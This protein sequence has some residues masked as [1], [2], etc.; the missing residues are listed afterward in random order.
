M[1]FAVK[2]VGKD[3]AYQWYF[4]R[5]EGS[6]K[7]VAAASYNTAALV[8]TANTKNDGTKFR[9]RIT[10]GLGNILVSSAATLTQ[11]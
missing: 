10:D 3:L 2:A 5:P 6:W 11:S 8:I 9:C 7:K 1:T 4:M